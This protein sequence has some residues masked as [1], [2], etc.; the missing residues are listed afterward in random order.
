MIDSNKWFR[1]SDKVLGNKTASL[2][3]SFHW[4]RNI[5]RHCKMT[6]KYRDSA[7]LKLS[8]VWTTVVPKYWKN[9]VEFPFPGLMKNFICYS[10]PVRKMKKKKQ[11]LNFGKFKEIRRPIHAVHSFTRSHAVFSK[12]K[13]AWKLLNYHAT[14]TFNQSE[15]VFLM[16]PFFHLTYS[17]HDLKVL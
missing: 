9:L 11:F 5:F 6:L 3:L 4:C 14:V 2:F 13:A 16:W 8:D 15:C 12:K 7:P 10:C 17:F 1:C